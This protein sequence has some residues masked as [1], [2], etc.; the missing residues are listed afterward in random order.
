MASRKVPK[1]RRSVREAVRVRT[2]YLSNL[3]RKMKEI[4]EKQR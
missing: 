3:H 2:M 4:L 1:N